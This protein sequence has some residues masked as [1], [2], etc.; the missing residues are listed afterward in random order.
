MLLVDTSRVVSGMTRATRSE[1]LRLGEEL[2]LLR[3]ELY[4]IVAQGIRDVIA[5]ATDTER[6]GGDQRR[7]ELREI[8]GK[9]PPYGLHPELAGT[10]R[11]ALGS[12]PLT[13]VTPLAAGSSSPVANDTL[14]ASLP[15]SVNSKHA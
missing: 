13:P 1:W 8:Y 5:S 9:T 14:L 15:R 11:L 3:P 7:A 12:A 2:K 6:I 4:E 10:D